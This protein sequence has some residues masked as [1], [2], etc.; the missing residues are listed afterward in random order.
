MIGKSS[1]CFVFVYV[2]EG[3]C[4]QA[5]VMRAELG[6]GCERERRDPG[7]APLDLCECQEGS[8][9]AWPVKLNFS[10]REYSPVNI[11]IFLVILLHLFK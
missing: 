11:C 7:D 6:Q 5:G 1:F 9:I 8:G 10:Q 2:H 3:L 4:F